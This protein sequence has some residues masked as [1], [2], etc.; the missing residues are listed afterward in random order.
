M[1]IA[2]R[3]WFVLCTFLLSVLL[4]IDRICI[5]AAET[6]VATDLGLT[7]QQMGWVMSAFALGYALCQ[8]PAGVLADRWG[9]TA[10][11]LATRRLLRQLKLTSCR[12][13]TAHTRSI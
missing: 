6:S 12:G 11:D 13:S 5:S 3:Y 2:T 7:S 4:Y 1:I 9:V 10:W 8:A